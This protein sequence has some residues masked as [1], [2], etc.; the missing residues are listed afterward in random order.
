[1]DP[2]SNCPLGPKCDHAALPKV[3]EVE[4]PKIPLIARPG[5][6]CEVLDVQNRVPLARRE[7]RAGTVIAIVRATE[8]FWNALRC[9]LVPPLGSEKLHGLPELDFHGALHRRQVTD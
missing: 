1:M 4:R 5:L 3:Q 8:D 7:N 6:R 9:I 2:A